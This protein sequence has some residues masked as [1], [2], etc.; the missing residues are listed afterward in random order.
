MGRVHWIDLSWTMFSAHEHMMSSMSQINVYSVAIH[1]LCK[2]RNCTCSTVCVPILRWKITTVSMGDIVFPSNGAN[3]KF[4]Y[5]YPPNEVWEGTMNGLQM[6]VCVQMCVVNIVNSAVDL[7]L[8]LHTLTD[9]DLF[10]S[11]WPLSVPTHITWLQLPFDL[12]PRYKGQ[13]KIQQVHIFYA[14]WKFKFCLF[15]IQSSFLLTYSILTQD[16]LQQTSLHPG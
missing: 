15:V 13:H 9:R 11:G 4:T 8:L 6:W 14:S 12:W 16:K 5:L 1:F 3:E 10:W 7:P 2:R